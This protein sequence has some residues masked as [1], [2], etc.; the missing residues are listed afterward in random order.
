MPERHFCCGSAGTYNLLQPDIAAA[1]GQRKAAHIESVDP[2]IIAAGNLGCMVQIGRYHGAAG[3]AH[4][5]AARLGDRRPDAA[6]RLRGRTLREPAARY[7]TISRSTRQTPTDA[8][9]LVTPDSGERG[10]DRHD[11]ESRDLLCRRREG[12]RRRQRQPLRGNHP[13]LWREH[14]GR[15][16]QAAGRRGL[17]GLDRARCRRSCALAN[18]HKRAALS[19]QHRPQYRPRLALGAARGPGGGRSRPQDEP[20]PRDRREARLRGGRA[21]RQ[22]PDDV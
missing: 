6:P 1:L 5:R 8:A 10:G 12:A 16:R 13:P 22:L 19:D 7:R 21:G 14:H 20:H 3:R 9:R 4:R 17:S 18:K 15:R 11:R 2:D